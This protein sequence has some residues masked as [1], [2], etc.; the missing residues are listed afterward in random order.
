[1]GLGV[2]GFGVE[3]SE[4]QGCLPLV[5]NEEMGRWACYADD[6]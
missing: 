4:A 2:S 6:S 3:G 1:M 5:G